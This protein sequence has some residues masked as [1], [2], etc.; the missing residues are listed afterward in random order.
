MVSTQQFFESL[1]KKEGLN[2][3]KANPCNLLDFA[4]LYLNNGKNY[5][6]NSREKEVL[7]VILGGRCNIRVEG[8]TFEN[9]GERKNVFK[10]PL[11]P[12]MCPAN[13][14][15]KLN[16]LKTVAW[17]LHYVMPQAI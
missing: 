16:L 15:L 2:Q 4:R 14:N 5:K 10:V 8:K 17:K 6:A 13:K 9:I 1:G 3:L 7:I 11:M 12:F